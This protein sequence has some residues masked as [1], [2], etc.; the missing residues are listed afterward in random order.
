MCVCVCVWVDERCLFM[1]CMSVQVSGRSWLTSPLSQLCCRCRYV[2]SAEERIEA[3]SGIASFSWR[4]MW[5]EGMRLELGILA[6]M[7]E[8][9]TCM[10][11]WWV[12]MACPEESTSSSPVSPTHC[13]APQLLHSHTCTT[14]N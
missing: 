6:V 3:E 4:C 1:Q 11:M 2:Q 9:C 8:V 10:V 13:P 14:D 5:R 7:V 12:G